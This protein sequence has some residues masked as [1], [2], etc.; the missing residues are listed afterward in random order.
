MRN[1]V[2]QEECFCCQEIDRCIEKMDGE[3]TCITQHTGFNNVCLDQY[4]LET[5]SIG[6]RTSKGRSYN[7]LRRERR[8]TESQ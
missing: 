6:L 2:K 8:T 1:V 7:V 4:V 5:A 3:I